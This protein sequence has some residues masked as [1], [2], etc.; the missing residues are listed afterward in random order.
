ML[1][2]NP[3][4][5]WMPARA[6]APIERAEVERRIGATDEPLELLTG[7][8]VNRNVRVGRERVLRIFHDPSAVGKEAALLARGWRSFRVPALLARGEDFLL[9]EHVEHAPLP[10]SAEHGATVGRAL[11][12]IHAVPYA[13]TGMLGADLAIVEPLSFSLR[14]YGQAQ[15]A[16]VAA[17]LDA[18]LRARLEDFFERHQEATS[19]AMD[20][21]VLSHC[22]FKAS[23][24][25]WTTR[26]ELLVLDWEFAWAGV[27]F[28]DLGQLLRWHPP[29]PFV[30]AFAEAYAAAGGVLVAGWRRFAEAIDLCNLVGL[31]RLPAARASGEVLRR[32]VQTLDRR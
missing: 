29:E 21:A 24:L 11:A 23:N 4:R 13:E 18:S 28:I 20:A 32:I 15:L 25:H 9:L 31:C 30:S 6:Q 22:D 8:L 2:P 1:L 12:E 14:G 10:A 7:G 17:H 19:A 16:D 5:A 26:G 3:E 27:R